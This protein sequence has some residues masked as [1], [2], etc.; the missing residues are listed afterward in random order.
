[1]TTSLCSFRP[2]PIIL[3]IFSLIRIDLSMFT[4][5]SIRSRL[6][7]CQADLAF[8]FSA[9][10]IMFPIGL[11]WRLKHFRINYRCSAEL[12]GCPL[13]ITSF[14]GD[15]LLLTYKSTST[16]KCIWGTFNLATLKSPEVMC[17]T[18]LSKLLRFFLISSISSIWSLT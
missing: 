13:S 6:M 11:L 17:T 16:I 9:V 14:T 8:I 3:V 4:L 18:C 5:S 15:F 10:W 7:V 1:M 12:E 2:L